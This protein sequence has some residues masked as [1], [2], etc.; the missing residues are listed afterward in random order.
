MSEPVKLSFSRVSTFEICERKWEYTYVHQRED[1]PGF[2]AVLGSFV[3]EVLENLFLLP[4]GQRDLDAARTLATTLFGSF[5]QR[6]D[7]KLVVDDEQ[8][9]KKK[10]WESISSLWEMENP[11]TQ[12]VEAV[13][14]PF[15]IV[16]G[17]VWLRGYIDRIDRISGN[18]HIV[19]YK[20]G[21]PPH[22][23]FRKPK[24]KQLQYYGLAVQETT[25]ETPTRGKL[26]YLGSEIVQTAINQKT[27]DETKQ[28]L[29]DVALRIKMAELEGYT[30]TPGPLCG[31]CPFVTECPE[32][33]N[34]IK[35]RY[36]A[37]RLKKTA[38]HHQLAKSLAT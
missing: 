5:N 28:S 15:D 29:Q 13:E 25:G 10:A 18:L 30:P 35:E 31:W 19:D 34:E 38:P 23:N 27:I 17:D 4:S 12:P 22:Y 20:T 21:K 36:Q 7:Y 37:G 33:Q 9:F 2:P 32:G 24:L 14:H 16:F 6:E 1:P 26:Y 8:A 11:D 3:H